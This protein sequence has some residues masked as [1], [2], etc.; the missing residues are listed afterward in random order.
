MRERNAV[1]GL[2]SLFARDD[3]DAIEPYVLSDERLHVSF[4]SS[5]SST[6]AIESEAVDERV[7]AVSIDVE[8]DSGIAGWNFVKAD[9]HTEN[10]EKD[11]IETN[12]PDSSPSQPSLL[13]KMEISL[14]RTISLWTPP[15]TLRI[16]R[17]F[18]GVLQNDIVLTNVIYMEEKT[19]PRGKTTTNGRVQS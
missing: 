2:S 6:D 10:D 19:T 8:N 17:F 5:S 15:P 16:I 12:I 4:S 3:E 9:E 1:R 14:V 13:L 7:E 11:E 18:G